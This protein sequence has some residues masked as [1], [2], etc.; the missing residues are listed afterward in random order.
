MTSIFRF[1]EENWKIE[2]R[3]RDGDGRT[4]QKMEMKFL[5]LQAN[6]EWYSKYR[7]LV[8]HPAWIHVK[9]W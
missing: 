1:D 5:V 2:E 9:I 3:R 4:N 7:T 8:T 6:L